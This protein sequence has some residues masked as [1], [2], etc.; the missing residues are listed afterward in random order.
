MLFF[1][2]A[3]FENPTRSNRADLKL[4]SYKRM[5]DFLFTLKKPTSSTLT[6]I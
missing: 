4:S 3:L 1:V 5:G 2:F 6:K